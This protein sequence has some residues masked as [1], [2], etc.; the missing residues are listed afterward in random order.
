[1]TETPIVYIDMDDVLCDFIGAFNE[2]RE[3]QPWIKYPQSQ[4][5]FFRDLKPLPHAVESMMQIK[6]Y[7][8]TGVNDAY[9]LTAPSVKNPYCYI[10]KRLWVKF[11]L[12][13]HWVE[14]LIIC[15]NKGLLKGHILIDDNIEGK[16]QEN[17]KGKVIQFGSEE[18]P[19]WKTIMQLE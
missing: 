14:R 8:E 4:K 11:H 9:I 13:D 12:G 19:N 16:G 5:G 6:E 1:M 15:P 10:E 17:F 2:A 3:K 18:F 7:N